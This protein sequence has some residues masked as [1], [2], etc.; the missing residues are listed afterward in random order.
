MPHKLRLTDVARGGVRT[1]Y[2]ASIEVDGTVIGYVQRLRG[3]TSYH[4]HAD[5]L[6]IAS[7][8]TLA[9]LC[10]DIRQYLEQDRLVE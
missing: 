4:A 8:R 9:D 7:A 6:R 5:G 3:E 2:A 1:A 10:N